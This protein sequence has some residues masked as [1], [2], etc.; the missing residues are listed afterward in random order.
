MAAPL[1]VSIRRFEPADWPQLWPML[2]A[3][4]EAGD[5]YAYAPD[6]REA[7]IRNIWIEAPAVTF[8]ACAP[9]GQ[10][11]GTYF[12]RRTSPGSVR[13][14]ATAAMSSRR[15]RRVGG[16]PLRCAS[17]RSARPWR[18]LSGDAVQPGRVDQRA[19]DPVVAAP[20]LHGGR[21]AAKAFH[22]MKLGYVDALVMYKELVT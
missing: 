17:T 20:R 12:I 2:R 14:S 5:T 18:W 4:F 3:T 6:S 1:P 11:V 9:D 10:L 16:S 15:P 19:R 7:D 13:M 21:D 22:H 8:V